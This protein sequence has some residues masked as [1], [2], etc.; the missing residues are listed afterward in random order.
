M[1]GVNESIIE[2][3]R[4]HLEEAYNVTG[5]QLVKDLAKK[6]KI[7]SNANMSTE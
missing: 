3:E 6:K 5:A 1:S 2:N 7:R 4:R